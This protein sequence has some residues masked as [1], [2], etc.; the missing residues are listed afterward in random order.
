M[1]EGLLGGILGE[2][3]EKPEVEATETL[4]GADAFA[5]AIAAKLAGNDPQV[6][7][8]TSTFLGKQSRLLDIQAKHLE[9]EH[10]ARLH[11]LQG[12]AREVGLRRPG[13]RLR[14]GF[15][16]FIALLATAIGI[17]LVVM[18]RDAVT[19]RQ[20][21]VEPLRIPSTLTAHGIDGAIVA[22]GLLDELGRLQDATRSN[23]AARG[24]TGAW[25]GNIKL[26][27]PE[28][29]VSLGEI[30]APASRAVRARP[31]RLPS[32][33]TRGHSRYGG[34]AISIPTDGMRSRSRSARAPWE[35]RSPRTV[36]CF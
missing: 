20:V 4:T 35:V 33:S 19:S 3:D 11:Y 34:P 15:Q 21:V 8:D 24:L 16:L 27:V 32:T 23:S 14:V 36:P 31:S 1:A 29:G 22:G 28:T 9:D 25:T 26:D 30:F 13:L 18:V 7:R 6:A 2:E 5:A 12:Q 10:A 17:G